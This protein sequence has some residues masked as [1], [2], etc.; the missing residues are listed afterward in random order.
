MAPAPD[1][2]S[3]KAPHVPFWKNPFVL[4][5]LIGAAILTVLPVIQART[6]KA[7]PPI[8]H[9]GTWSLVDEH[10][11]AFGS[12]DLKGHVWIASFFFAR[13]PSICPQL[14]QDFKKLAPHME[15]LADPPRLVSFSVDPEADTPEVLKAYAAKLGAQHATWTFVTGPLEQMRDLLVNHMFVDMGARESLQGAEGL[16]EISHAAKFVL[17]DQNG[18]VRGA[19]GTDEGSRGNLINAA[20]L[21]VKHGPNP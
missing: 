14:Q 1:D 15:D 7:P 5:F 11:H 4:A 8:S 19:W 13:C 10:G 6:L 17:V 3:G 12:E 20:R 2:A 18:D 21:L 16:Y 9:L